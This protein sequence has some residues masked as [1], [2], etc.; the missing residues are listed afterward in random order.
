M[1]LSRRDFLG[2]GAI[3]VLGFSLVE[4]P[5]LG[6]LALGAEPEAVVEVP[7]IWMAT[8]SCSGCSVSLL[9]S[10][11]PTIEELL[12]DQV[13]PGKHV[14]LG[15]HA[16]IMAS[17]GD[18]AIEAMEKIAREHK[19]GYVLVVDGAVATGADGLYCAVGERDGKPITGYE[20]VRDLGRDALA[21][22]AVGACASSG[23]IPAAGSNPTEAVPV[24]IVLE[25]EGIK[26]PLVNIPG[27]PP[28]P[29]WIVGTIATL[30]LGGVDALGLDGNHRPAPFFRECIHDNCPYRGHFEKGDFAEKFGDHGCLIKLGCK[31]P[32]TYAD[33]PIRKFNNGTS[34]CVEA[35]H[36]CIGCCHPDFPFEGSLFKPVEPAQL[37]FPAAYPSV[38]PEVAKQADKGTYAAIGIIGAG[39]FAAGVG[40]TAAAKKLHEHHES[41]QNGIDQSKE[42][43]DEGD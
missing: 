3:S 11:S 33:C 16:T 6:R 38:H 41:E 4:V 36:P 20:H 24:G 15:F 28:H 8:G 19:G 35:G 43:A 42:S 22:L 30:L 26:T 31:G 32:I 5:G 34:W 37:A 25:R 18:Q 23:G 12:L 27:C 29:D 21:V 13:L 10:A 1:E 17:Q 2:A 39:A 9:N 14:S 40:V 7:V